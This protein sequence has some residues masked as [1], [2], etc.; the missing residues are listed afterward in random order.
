M[1]I[2]CLFHN[3][4]FFSH[5]FIFSTHLC[6][7]FFIAMEVVKPSTTCHFWRSWKRNYQSEHQNSN[8]KKC[9]TSARPKNVCVFVNSPNPPWFSSLAEYNDLLQILWISVT[10]LKGNI[11]VCLAQ[12]CVTFNPLYFMFINLIYWS[13]ILSTL[14]SHVTWKFSWARLISIFKILRIRCL[15]GKLNQCQRN[16]LLVIL[17]L[18]IW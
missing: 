12:V 18:V 5:T 8:N 4:V 10:I 7:I 15:H 14:S 17:R 9:F 2:Y 11:N 16:F 1:Y 6:I 13:W 3:N